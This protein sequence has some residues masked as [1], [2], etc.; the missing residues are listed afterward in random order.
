MI[1]QLKFLKVITL[2]AALVFLFDYGR[3]WFF[4]YKNA[5][6]FIEIVIGFSFSFM[7]SFAFGVA[8]Y[9]VVYELEKRYSWQEEPKKRAIYGVIGAVLIS[10][11]TIVLLRVFTVLVIEQRDWNYFITNESYFVYLYSL[12]ITLVIVMAFYTAHFYKALTKQTITAHKTVAET[13]TAKYESLKSQLDPHFLFNS[14]NV[15]TSLIEENP[16]KAEQFTAKLSKTYR[17]VLEQKEKTLVPLK[18]ELDFAKGYMELLKMRFENALEFEIPQEVS[19]ANYKIVPLSLQLLLE[20]AVKHNSLSEERPLLINIEEKQGML[21]VTNNY[22]EKKSIKKGTGIGL[23][24]IVTR[25]GLLTDRQVTIEQIADTFSVSLPLLTQKTTIMKTHTTNQDEKYNRALEKVEKIKGF[26]ANLTSYIFVNAFLVAVNYYTSWE[27]KWFI[28]PMMG[29]GIGVVF[30]YFE[31]FGN[32]PFLS[33]DWEEKKIKELM[34]E[35][36]KERWE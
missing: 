21:V 18:E 12:I 7:Y 8:N 33:K 14:L 2:V 3:M 10:M 35:E 24:N 36:D 31:T 20:N 15:L 22:Q 5:P 11:I 1:K 28:Y 4:D 25:Y 29:W 6:D 23:S 13:E 27:H 16:E 17:Y 32:Y 19:N 30:H 34:D 9:W 26:Y